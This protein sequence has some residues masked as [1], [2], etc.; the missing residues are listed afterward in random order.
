MGELVALDGLDDGVGE[1]AVDGDVALLPGPPRIVAL[2]RR[3]GEIVEAVLD[4]PEERVGE[5]VVHQV[6]GLGVVLHEA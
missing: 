3:V 6:V 5:L 2:V 4:E 1:V